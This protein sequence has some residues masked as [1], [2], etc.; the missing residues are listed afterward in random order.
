M[1]KRWI[2]IVLVPVV[3]VCIL[4]AVKFWPRTVP[5]E[6]CSPVYRHYA[7][8]EGVDASYVCQYQVDDTTFVDVTLLHATTDSAWVSLC[9]EF[10]SPEY[11]DAFKEGVIH[12]NSVTH[13]GVS[14]DDPHILVTPS[15]VVDCDLL[16][17]S[18]PMMTI[19]IFHTENET[20]RNA[21]VAKT[22]N[23]L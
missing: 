2:T 23:D 18:P 8:Q 7:E 21:I 16:V 4:A 1:K 11:P 14:D 17:I 20:Q 19:C 15:V 5:L 9:L 10:I 6:D 22:I 13:W 3:I 12:G